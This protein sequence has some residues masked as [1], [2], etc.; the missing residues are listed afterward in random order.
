MLALLMAYYQVKVAA[1]SVASSVQDS[2]TD[3]SAQEFK[4][5]VFEYNF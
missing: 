1:I 5:K 2:G 3:L 4:N